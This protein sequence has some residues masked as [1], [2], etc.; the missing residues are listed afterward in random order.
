MV[1]LQPIV[2]TTDMDGAVEW[3]RTVLESDPTYAS[4][5]WTA[6]PVGDAT[7]GVHAVEEMAD[8]S[9]V[10]LSLVATEPLEEVVA[11][12]GNSGVEPERGIQDET[13]G[14]SILL[15]DPAGNPVQVNEHEGGS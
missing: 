1:R 14:R 2:Y 12:L 9:R 4:E 15:R 7:L 6:F 3:Y 10:E 5:M 13:F 11:R 8:G